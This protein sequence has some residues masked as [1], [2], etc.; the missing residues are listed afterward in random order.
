MSK[1]PS[2]DGSGADLSWPLIDNEVAAR[3]AARELS[4]MGIAAV[5][6][7]RSEGWEVV[8]TEDPIPDSRRHFANAFLFGFLLGYEVRQEEPP[9]RV[10]ESNLLV[11]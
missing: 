4:E 6:E 11:R 3:I 9:P 8:L 7:E 1:S 2:R 5:P 10:G